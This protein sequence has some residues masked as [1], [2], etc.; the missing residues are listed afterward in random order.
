MW[1]HCSLRHSL[2]YVFVNSAPEVEEGGMGWKAGSCLGF[3]PRSV[4]RAAPSLTWL[5]VSFSEKLSVSLVETSK[6]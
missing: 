3:W 5:V 6:W 2:N 4:G 1:H